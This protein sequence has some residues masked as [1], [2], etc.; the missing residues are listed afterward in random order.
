MNE[1]TG[2]ING[3]GQRHAL[4]V[5]RWNDFITSRLLEGA[6][7]ALKRHGVA[8]EDITVVHIPGSYEMGPTARK[9]AASGK[10][11]AVTCLGVVIRGD[12]AHFDFVAGEASRLIAQAS[13]DTGIPVMFG[14]LTTENVEQAMDRAGI[15][16]GNKGAET[17][18]A[19]VEM[20]SL[21]KLLG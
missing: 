13:Y 12:T 18:I 8:D 11:D 7:A 17:A 21:Y 20:A 3:A 15:K 5:A 19:A 14:V 6:L 2:G 1:L 10:Y 4:I 9:V 16:A